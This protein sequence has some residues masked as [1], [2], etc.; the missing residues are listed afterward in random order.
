VGGAGAKVTKAAEATNSDDDDGYANKK[1]GK[2]AAK[3]Q[4][5]QAI[6]EVR[7]EIP[8]GL[9]PGISSRALRHTQKKRG[10]K[11]GRNA[12]PTQDFG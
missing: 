10:G 8:G 6:I 3:L 5:G 4:K 7:G 9:R 11:T 12:T 2:W 1:A